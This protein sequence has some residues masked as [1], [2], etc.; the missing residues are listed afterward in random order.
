MALMELADTPWLDCDHITVCLA[1]N[2]PCA[3][4]KSLIRDLGWVGFR[5]GTVDMGG[6]TAV[7]MKSPWLFLSLDL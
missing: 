7:L 5:L 2:T 6:L 1:R 4:S 3:Q